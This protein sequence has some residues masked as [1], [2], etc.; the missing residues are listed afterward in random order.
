MAEK[1]QSKVIMYS[2]SWCPDCVRAKHVLKQLEVPF[3]EIDIDTDKDGY[4][5]VVEFNAGK[6][7]VPTIFF[8][9]GTALVEPSNSELVDK[10]VGI[11]MGA[12]TQK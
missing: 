4:Q 10:L 3:E 5:R 12:G 2:T 1:D 9:D 8:P 11:G 6:R 7:I